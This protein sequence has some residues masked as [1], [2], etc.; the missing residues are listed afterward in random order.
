MHKLNRLG[1]AMEIK[2]K[3]LE[4]IQSNYRFETRLC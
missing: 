4:Q 2:T 1:D 3:I